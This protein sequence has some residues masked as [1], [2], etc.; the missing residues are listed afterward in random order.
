MMICDDRVRDSMRDRDRRSIQRSF[1]ESRCYQ[2]LWLLQVELLEREF[3]TKFT[4][5]NDFR[6]DVS[7]AIGIGWLRLVG[8]FKL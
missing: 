8:S 6:A 5:L 4:M 2:T 1:E 3:P 7:G